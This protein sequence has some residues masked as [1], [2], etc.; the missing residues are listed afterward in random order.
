VNDTE[1]NDCVERKLGYE[2]HDELKKTVQMQN[3]CDS[4]A[5]HVEYQ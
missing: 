5:R 1:P 4:H 3:A 2:H